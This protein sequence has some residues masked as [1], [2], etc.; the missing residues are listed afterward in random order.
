[1]LTVSDLIISE[2]GNGLVTIADNAKIITLGNDEEQFTYY[3]SSG[4]ITSLAAGMVPM[5][6]YDLGLDKTTVELVI[7]PNVGSLT[8]DYNDTGD[9]ELGDLNLVL[10][11]WS[12]LEGNVPPEWI[13]QR[14]IGGSVGLDQLNGVLFNWGNTAAVATVPEPA[15]GCLA[16]AAFVLLLHNIRGGRR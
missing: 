9:V 1:M 11:N 2:T 12:E 7:D 16:M 6:M 3:I 10:F 15:T 14:P 4:L 5:A 8:G 13:N